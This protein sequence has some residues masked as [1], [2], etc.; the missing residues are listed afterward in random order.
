MPLDVE[1][2]FAR[3]ISI[4]VITSDDFLWPKLDSGDGITDSW[5]LVSVTFTNI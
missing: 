3:I 2:A 4:S 5:F 1:T